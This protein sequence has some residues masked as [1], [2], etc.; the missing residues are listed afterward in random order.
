MEDLKNRKE[1][2][3]V[4]DF[5]HTCYDTDD[6]LLNEIRHPM[7]SDFVVSEKDWEKAYEEAVKTGY[8]I[9]KHF[10]KITEITNIAFSEDKIRHLLESMNFSRYLYPDTLHVLARAKE[11][12]FDIVILS[13]GDM[14]WQDKKVSG[15]GLDKIVDIVEYVI[16]D[17]CNAKAA[18]VGNLRNNYKKVI[19]VDNKGANLD[20]VY[21]NY[22][23]VSTYF[24]NRSI[25]ELAD[26]EEKAYLQTRYSESRKIAERNALPVHKRCFSLEEVV[27]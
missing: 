27:L 5:D 16:T 14:S 6:F 8:S 24:I 9:E 7:L 11:K 18:V 2:V 12:K 17:E 20:K 1:Q 13:F 10:K 4:L 3:L 25:G 26:P 19:Y 21:E 23:D 22:K 15:S